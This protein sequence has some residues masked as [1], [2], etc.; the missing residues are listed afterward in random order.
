MKIIYPEDATPLNP[1]E[2]I[3][4]IPS[5]ITTREELNAWED[6]N[7]ASIEPW[8]REA[9]DI[10]SINFMQEL[11]KRMFDNTWQWAGKFRTSEKTLASPGI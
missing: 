11:H 7:I 8:A 3:G 10:I 2:L 9:K 1:D 6:W 5:H 4:L